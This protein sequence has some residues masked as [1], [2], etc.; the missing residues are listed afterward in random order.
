MNIVKFITLLSSPSKKSKQTKCIRDCNN[1]LEEL[2]KL[3]SAW[4]DHPSELTDEVK[5]TI[6]DCYG[7]TKLM[8]DFYERNSYFSKS[9]CELG[10]LILERCIAICEGNVE[11][12]KVIQLCRT[13]INN[14]ISTLWG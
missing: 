14:C 5:N 3:I 12:A 1:L 7:Y 10:K 13:C 8:V 2:E 11:L 9:I 6:L 4:S